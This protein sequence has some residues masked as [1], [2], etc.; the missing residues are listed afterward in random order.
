MTAGSMCC[1]SSSV[2]EEIYKIATI[3]GK[4][5]YLQIIK[6]KNNYK[7]EYQRWEIATVKP[8]LKKAMYIVAKH[9]PEKFRI[10]YQQLKLHDE[11]FFEIADQVL[12]KI[13]MEY[14]FK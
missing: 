10:M 14:S 1:F 3:D 4:I 11:E 9:H 5:D 7:S 8:T 6:V 2:V 12:K 13:K